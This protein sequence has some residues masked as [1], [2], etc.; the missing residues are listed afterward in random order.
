MKIDTGYD[1]LQLEII[2]GKDDGNR[3]QTTIRISG[4]QGVYAYAP[5]EPHASEVCDYIDVTIFGTLERGVLHEVLQ[6]K[7]YP[8]EVTELKKQVQYLTEQLEA[9]KKQYS[10]DRGYRS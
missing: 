6:V 5:S 9:Q 8:S 2:D 10:P 3:T 7:H 1:E 4:T